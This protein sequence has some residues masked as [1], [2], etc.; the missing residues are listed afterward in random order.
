[1]VWQPALGQLLD[2]DYYSEDPSV[3]LAVFSESL[4]V[5]LP[6]SWLSRMFPGS[7]RIS[8]TSISGPGG[9]NGD[10]IFKSVIFFE[11]PP[12]SRQIS[13]ESMPV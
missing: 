1:M 8:F 12:F 9:A 2:W 10:P 11:G 3:V 5:I 6:S 4:L 13:P 7:E